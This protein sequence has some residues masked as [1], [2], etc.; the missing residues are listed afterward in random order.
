MEF[1]AGAFDFQ[2]SQQNH[3]K[4]NKNPNIQLNTIINGTNLTIF[5]TLKKDKGMT[6]KKIHAPE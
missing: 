3:V 6:A 5:D 1:R 4:Y 2:T